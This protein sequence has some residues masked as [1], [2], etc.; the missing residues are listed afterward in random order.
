M[1]AMPR[2]RKVEK[3]RPI[4]VAAVRAALLTWFRASHRAMPWRSPGKLADPYRVLV[5]EAMLQQT[6]VATVIDY[7]NRFIDALPTMQALAAVDEQQ[8]LRLWQGLGYYRRARHLHA[9]AKFIVNE[10]GGL[11]PDTVEGLLEL[12]G[13]GRYTAGAIASIAFGRSAPILDGNVARVISRVMAINEVI[14]KPAVREKL[15][16]LAG[17]WAPPESKRNDP[18]D[19]NQAMMELGA[20][21]CTP[22]T[23]KCL[24]C[25]VASICRANQLG[26]PE[27]YPVVEK[28]KQPRA[29]M[30]RI[31][32]VLKGD[33]RLLCQRPATGLWSNMWQQPTIE[34]AGL[35][36]TE[37]VRQTYG[38]TL[39][40]PVLITHFE[41]MTTHR[42]IRFELWEARCVGGRLKNGQWRSL[43]DLDDLPLPNPQARAVKILAK[44]A[45]IR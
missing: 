39:E 41:H 23:P 44:S 14:Q 8:V 25:P 24:L 20:T 34:D 18:G 11:V 5:S 32:S 40:E 38:I 3:E 29:V 31:I 19:F 1:P 13:V 26:K 27:A 42:R 6:Q 43:D 16:S 10:R 36:A 4:D 45:A 12:P 15:W 35:E 28:R 7:F 9:A 30:H 2:P 21:V 22:R 17:E 33:A 37:H